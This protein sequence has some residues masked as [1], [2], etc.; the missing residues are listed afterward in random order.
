MKKNLKEIEETIESICSPDKWEKK[1]F[2][3][4]V[5]EEEKPVEIYTTWREVKGLYNFYIYLYKGIW[6]YVRYTRNV[7]LEDFCEM[8]DVKNA[9]RRQGIQVN[10]K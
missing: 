8:A 7:F 1:S 4:P 2:Y 5:R 6:V 9:L 3:R 10:K